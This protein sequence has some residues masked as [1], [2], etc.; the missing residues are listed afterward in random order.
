M[1]EEYCRCPGCGVCDAHVEVR[2]LRKALSEIWHLAFPRRTAIG[3]DKV[4]KIMDIVE[5]HIDLSD[6]KR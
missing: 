2:K 6:L 4:G 1:D 5:A 3:S